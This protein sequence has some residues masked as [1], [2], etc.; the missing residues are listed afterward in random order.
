MTI[1]FEEIAALIKKLIPDAHVV[2]SDMT[3]GGDHFEI[4]VTSESFRGKMLI[5]QHRMIQQ[6]LDPA[7]A[8][9]RI[10][11]IRIK[12]QTPQKQESTGGDFNILN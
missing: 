11:A 10:H 8:D 5:D 12:T 1:T 4:T 6:A 2:V 3:G 7:M 9:G